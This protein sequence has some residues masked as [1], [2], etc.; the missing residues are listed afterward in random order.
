MAEKVKDFYKILGVDKNATQDD[1][2]KAYR[3][4]SLKY[5]PDRQAGKSD[6]DI[7]KAEETFK[8]VTEAYEVLGD[9]EKRKEYDTPRSSFEFNSSS[10]S[11]FN[12]IFSHFRNSGFDFGMKSNRQVNGSN[13]KIKINLT[14]EE[15]Q[16]GVTKKIRYKK[17]T[18]CSHCNGSGMSAS[19]RKKTCKQCGGS[20]TVFRG[21]FMSLT[22]ICPSCGGLGYTI[23]N[24]CPHCNGHGIAQTTEEVEIKIPQGANSEVNLAYRG[25]GNE[26]PHGTGAKG[27]L[28]V[29]INELPHKKFKRVGKNLHFDIK[30]KL[31]NVVMGCKANITTLDGKVLQANIPIGTND[32]YQMKFKGYGIS[33]Y[34]EDGVGDMIGT[35]KII[36]PKE[37]NQRERELL[38]E[39][40]KQ[41]HF[42]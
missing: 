32:G 29:E 24:P 25:F 37:L 27:N 36:M 15:I 17:F 12:D 40:K 20:G 30:L 19:S 8:Q 39:L 33:N 35:I 22:S 3:K 6:A 13:I 28:I 26:A 41:D 42:K 31:I 5:H 9:V 16:S 2:K 23:E 4:M 14:L 18:L 7:K 34:P 38:N 21:G 1:I 10:A 11:D